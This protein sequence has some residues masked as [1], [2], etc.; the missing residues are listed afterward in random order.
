[1]SREAAVEF[2]AVVKEHGLT[3]ASGVPCSYL[4]HLLRTAEEDPEIR[5]VPAVR[6]DVAVGVATGAA[7]RGAPAVVLMQNSGLGS[8]INP[9]TSLNLLYR[10]PVLLVISWRGRDGRDAPE[11]HIMG[12]RLLPLLDTLALPYEV[13]A[14]ETIRPAVERALTRMADGQPAALV[15]PSGVM[16]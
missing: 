10:I 13:L 2:W 8:V 4:K 16:E 7:L 15:V 9:L 12:E 6:E 1:M 11:H 5:Y 14:P 3:L